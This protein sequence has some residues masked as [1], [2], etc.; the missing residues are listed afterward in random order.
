MKKDIAWIVDALN[1]EDDPA[2]ILSIREILSRNNKRVVTLPI[3]TQDELD[4]MIEEGEED[5]REGRLISASD[6]KSEI[7]EWRKK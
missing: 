5:I 7:Q 1:K 3:L 2:V 4:A 6:L